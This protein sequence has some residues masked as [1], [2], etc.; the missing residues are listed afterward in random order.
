MLQICS[1]RL[2]EFTTKWGGKVPDLSTAQDV[3]EVSVRAAL[4]ALW[5]HSKGQWSL[6][7]EII[8]TEVKNQVN[9][10]NCGVPVAFI[11][12]TLV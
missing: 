8:G 7:M 5:N 1:H 10:T 2:H 12:E 3:L 4:D 6:V 9:L 11:Y